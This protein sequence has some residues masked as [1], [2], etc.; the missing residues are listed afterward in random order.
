MR[1]LK[2]TR[3]HYAHLLS[4]LDT[5]NTNGD[6]SAAATKYKNAGL[7]FKCLQWDALH[8]AVDSQ[9]IC[10]ELYS[11]LNDDHIQSALNAAFKDMGVSY[12]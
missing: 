2:I 3:E 8:T 4:A 12:A 5:F 11:Y 7:S 6:I 9:W 10:E 1:N